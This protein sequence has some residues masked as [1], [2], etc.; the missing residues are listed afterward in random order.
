MDLEFPASDPTV[1]NGILRVCIPDE[2]GL[3][4][5]NHVYFPEALAETRVVGINTNQGV[6]TAVRFPLPK[7][8]WEYVHD[9]ELLWV[10]ARCE[11]VGIKHGYYQETC[12]INGEDHYG[13]YALDDYCRRKLLQAYGR[14]ERD[15]SLAG[16]HRIS[17]EQLAIFDKP[18][19]YEK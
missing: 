3:R 10:K 14:T 13:P 4:P 18:S 2:G 8:S 1:M 12:Q 6:M 19:A 7:D 5:P 15:F 17:P 11:W 16:V 9:V